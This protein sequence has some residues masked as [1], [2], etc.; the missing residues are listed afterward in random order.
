MEKI[1]ERRFVFSTEDIKRPIEVEYED[2]DV[3]CPLIPQDIADF[4][5]NTCYQY[6]KFNKYE[7]DRYSIFRNFTNGKT[8]ADVFTS[9]ESK[10]MTKDGVNIVEF[11]DKMLTLYRL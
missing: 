4:K 9:A 7:I 11:A 5:Q 10:H 6:N 2:L 3:K 8:M 1:F